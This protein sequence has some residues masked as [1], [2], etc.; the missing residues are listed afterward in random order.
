MEEE[1][2]RSTQEKKRTVIDPQTGVAIEVHPEMKTDMVMAFISAAYLLIM[3]GFFFW[4]L[5][6]I[7]VGQF[8][9]IHWI[10]Y[11]NDGVLA[12]TSFRSVAF[13]FIGGALGGI[14]NGFRSILF[15]HCEKKVFGRRFIWKYI[16]A[17]WIG[18]SLALFAYA[19]IRSGVAVFGGGI[20]AGGTGTGQTLAL[21][22]IGVLAGYGS[23]E[24]FVWL[25]AQVKRIFSVASLKVPNLIGKSEQDAQALLEMLN[26][27][28]GNVSEELTEDP[29][30]VGKVLKQTPV[31][32]EK[33]A[34]G[35]RVDITI[36]IKNKG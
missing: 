13:T 15:W 28:L 25:D 34:S 1:R 9:L 33:I 2:I 19:F 24:F 17:P 12:S 22:T 29:S 3:L 36:A 6:D 32:D 21:F 27:G 35:G 11:K 16:S 23:R 14:V 31:A 20:P 8:S 5:F 30:L 10:G 4:Q 26:L 7:W 18:C